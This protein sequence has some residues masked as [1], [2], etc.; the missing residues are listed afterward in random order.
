MLSINRT[1]ANIKEKRLISAI[2]LLKNVLLVLKN[3][4]MLSQIF[5]EYN[6][7]WDVGHESGDPGDAPDA[8]VLPDLVAEAAAL[9]DG[10]DAL[11]RTLVALGLGEAP[12][13]GHAEALLD[14]AHRLGLVRGQLGVVQRKHEQMHQHDGAAREHHG[15]DQQ[16]LVQMRHHAARHFFFTFT[17]SFGL[18]DEGKK[19]KT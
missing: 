11:G 1:E 19:L 5:L 10:D 12:G 2:F 6:I 8:G 17:K 14:L 16:V 3:L 15:R 13:V 4:Q 7:P 9:R 18:F